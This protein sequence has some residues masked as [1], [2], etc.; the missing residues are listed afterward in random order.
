MKTKTII[1]NTPTRLHKS[2]MIVI[3]HS[4][5]SVHTSM[6][7]HSSTFE[8]SGRW[9]TD[10]QEKKRKGKDVTC[11]QVRWP[12]LGI[13]VLHL[14]HPSA[15]TQQWVVN[16]HTH[17]HTHTH[18]HRE[19]TPGADSEKIQTCFKSQQHKCSCITLQQQHCFNKKAN[20]Q[21][22]FDLKTSISKILSN[23]SH[24]TSMSYTDQTVPCCFKSNT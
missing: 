20:Q 8:P 1:F 14:T 17:T 4:S 7:S 6:C 5:G 9:K 3:S 10:W 23:R 24:C 16:K 22:L 18:T 15:H 13:C 11:G 21:D 12:I 19:H 2:S